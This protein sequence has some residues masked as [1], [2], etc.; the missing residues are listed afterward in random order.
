M[1]DLG[2]WKAA[3]DTVDKYGRGALDE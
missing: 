1:N 3:Q 2:A